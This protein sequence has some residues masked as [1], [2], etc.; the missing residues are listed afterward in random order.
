ML[1]LCRMLALC[2]AASPLAAEQISLR[3][4]P[5]PVA[6]TAATPEPKTGIILRP[7]PRPKGIETAARNPANGLLGRLF[8]S[9]A[10]AP[11]KGS[12]CGDRAIRGTEVEAIAGRLTGCGIADPVRVTEVAGVKL[13]TPATLHCDTAKALK[14]WVEDAVQPA[15][16]NKVVQLRVAASYSCRP[17]NSKKGARI[18]EHGKGRAIDISGF[19]L[20]DGQE[21]T[22]LADY[23]ARQGAPIRK[24]HK[25]ACGT[26]GT[27]LGPGSDGHHMDHLHLDVASYR[28]GA[29]C[30]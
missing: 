29:Y 8:G 24:A 5:R 9:K 28:S 6:V 14:T 10:R 19:R 12:V 11:V 23:K 2:L 17:R 26:F 13:S 18:S 7:Q 25:A 20:S 3:P 22:V 21:L 27:T 15:F 4:L 1:R 30:R 16:A